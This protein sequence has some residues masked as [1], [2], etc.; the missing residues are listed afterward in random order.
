MASI[1][2]V[3]TFLL[4]VCIAITRNESTSIPKVIHKI[5]I[6]HNG[7]FEE[8][9]EPEIIEA[10]KSW[11]DKNPGYKI[12]LYNGNDCEQYL[13]DHYDK[14]HL[15]VYRR[16]R[17]YA[18]KCDFIRACIVYNEGGWY[19][20]WKTVCLKPLNDLLKH[21]HVEWVSSFDSLFLKERHNRT[22][23]MNN[24]FGGCPR[25]PLLKQYITDI[26]HNVQ[27]QY[28]GDI[29][30]DITG[31]GCFGG[32]YDKIKGNLDPKRTI[33]GQYDSVYHVIHNKK[34][35]RGKCSKCSQGQDWVNGN[36]YNTLW[37]N[38]TFYQ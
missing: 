27:T 13:I 21:R 25:H 19:S 18:C 28:Y 16:I 17:S 10:H 36:N 14:E 29:P 33:I 4:L 31:P 8:K 23:M 15:D 6:Q 24:F 32:S 20:D 1:Y 12:R 5:Y 38:K 7:Q 34:W 30:L 2:I 37:H 35:I 22:F 9:M 3:I 11:S 26:I